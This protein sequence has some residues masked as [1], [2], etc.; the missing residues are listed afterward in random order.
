MY[1]RECVI[2]WVLEGDV[3]PLEDEADRDLL[4][5][6]GIERMCNIWEQVLD[7]AAAKIKRAQKT[8]AR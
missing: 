7:V 2:P 3:G 1:G 4:I 6:E 8:Q 5:E